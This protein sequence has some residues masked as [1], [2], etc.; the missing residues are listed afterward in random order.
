MNAGNVD[1]PG[2][3]EAD[4]RP[5][6]ATA[7]VVGE[8]LVDV[9]RSPDGHTQEHPGGSPANVA[10]GLARL[11]RPVRL[12]T[13]IG[14]DARGRRVRDHLGASGVRLVPGSSGADRTSTAVA[15]LDAHGAAQYTFDL[16]WQVPS[17]T[18]DAGVAVLHTGSIAATLP[19][20]ADDVSRL[21]SAGARHATVTY[22]PNVRPGIMGE[23]RSVRPGIEGLVAACDVVKVSDEDLEWLYPGRDHGQLA[24][25]WLD[26][27]PALVVIT[28]GA[29]GALGATAGATVEV[30][31][32]TV[33]VADTV[34]AGDSYMAALI[35]GLWGAGLLGAANRPAL[36]R[37]TAETVRRVMTYAAAAAAITV[38]RP[39]ADPPHKAELDAVEDR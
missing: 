2:A 27:G 39:G 36:R 25:Q 11:G 26:R 38:S 13:W 5:P 7:L 18:V 4:R 35:D 6:A 24:A 12:A 10:V 19:P 21:I 14:S 23:A 1:A 31:A 3:T 8:A 17:L 34:G 29:R 16:D 28:R 30:P 33:S 22:D 32:P 37:I 20:G 15:D 9:V